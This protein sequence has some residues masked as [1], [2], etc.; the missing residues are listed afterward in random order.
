MPDYGHELLFG[1]FITPVAAQAQRVVELARLTEQVGLDLV[2]VQDHP[3]QSRFLDMWT[4]LSVIAARTTT[5]RVCPNVANLPLRP[6]SV[7]A[8][9]VA[10]LDLLSGGRVELGIGA[11][12]FWE[13]IAA[14]G[15]RR[16]RPGEAVRALEEGIAVIRAL[17][18]VGERVRIEG[19]HYRVVGAK[20]GPAPA[21]PVEI[22]IGG[23]KP[24]MLSLIGRVGDGW[25]P[26][27]PYAGPETLAERN[28][29]ID[30][31]AH[32]AGRDPTAVRRLYNVGGSFERTGSGFLN[33]PPAAWG[34]QLAELTLTQGMSAYFAIGDDPDHVRRFAAEVAPAVRELVAAERARS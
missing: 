26:S 12:T 10:S 25:L 14:M 2:T 22:W 7:L 9:S 24:R 4:L 30:E 21:H 6:P 32:A 33:G 31:A 15:G 3:Y 17:W 5:L 8:R 11:G 19:Q 23:L 34:E 27:S 1:T 13:P 18:N 16:L 28:A 20:P 29:I